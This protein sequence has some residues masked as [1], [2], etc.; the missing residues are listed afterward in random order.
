MPP[1]APRGLFH[2]LQRLRARVRRLKSE[3]IHLLGVVAQ[4]VH[5][6]TA[7]DL[8]AQLREARDQLNDVLELLEPASSHVDQALKPAPAEASNG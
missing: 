8:K 3:V 4:N 5:A 7:R 2:R 1:K 6:P